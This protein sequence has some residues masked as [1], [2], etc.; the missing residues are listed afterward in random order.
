MS[1][2]S[3]RGLVELARTS[4]GGRRTTDLQCKYQARLYTTKDSSN[5]AYKCT[6]FQDS[7][8]LPPH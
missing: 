5:T 4:E 3:L 2:F 1:I 7:P 8:F 6:T